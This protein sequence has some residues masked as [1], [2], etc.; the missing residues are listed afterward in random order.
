MTKEIIKIYPPS[1]QEQKE[2][3]YYTR[4]WKQKPVYYVSQVEDYI[5]Y[6]KYKIKEETN[7]SIFAI[8]YMYQCTLEEAIRQAKRA[9]KNT[10]DGRIY[11]LDILDGG[12]PVS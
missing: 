5:K 1:L 2:M 11:R 3:P 9:N 7:D 8:L 4:M 12:G 10:I 6:I